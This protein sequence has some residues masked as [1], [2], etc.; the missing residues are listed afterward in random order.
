MG[1][2]ERLIA[3]SLGPRPS[4]EVAEADTKDTTGVT[5]GGSPLSEMVTVTEVEL[6]AFNQDGSVPN[7]TVKVSS[8]VSASC[9]VAIVAVP[10]VDKVE[11]LIW[12]IWLKSLASA[13]PAVTVSGIVTGTLRLLE[14]FTV[15]VTVTDCPS[16]TVLGETDRLTVDGSSSS[17]IMTEK[18][19][20]PS[21]M[22]GLR[23]L[24][25][26]NTSKLSSPS[27]IASSSVCMVIVVLNWFA[28]ISTSSLK[29]V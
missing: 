16:E 10:L 12:L 4:L 24:T 27:I 26:I 15:T 17:L 6:P 19:N 25:L 21:V 1:A 28:G 11:T 13:E 5:E 2:D 23:S 20:R 9:S 7:A 29:W 22:S 14:A 18:R 8:S 3:T